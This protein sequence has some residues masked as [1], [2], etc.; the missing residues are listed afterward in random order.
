MINKP[1]DKIEKNKRALLEIRDL[2]NELKNDLNSI[3]TR[4]KHLQEQELYSV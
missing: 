4:I 1:K 3:D 2:H